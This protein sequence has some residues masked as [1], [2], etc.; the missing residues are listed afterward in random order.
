MENKNVDVKKNRNMLKAMDNY[1]RK[2]VGDEDLI[3]NIWFSVGCPDGA[4]YDEMTDYAEDE[5]TMQDMYK[6]FSKMVIL[7]KWGKIPVYKK[8]E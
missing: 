4:G 1:I 8:E 7:D 6:A 3:Y 5:E 2:Y